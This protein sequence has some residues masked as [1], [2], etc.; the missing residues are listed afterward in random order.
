LPHI[1]AI[2]SQLATSA[3]VSSHVMLSTSTHVRPSAIL[4]FNCLLIT[5]FF[6]TKLQMRS[7]DLV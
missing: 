4:L 2:Y 5:Q 1:Y 3:D 7:T 6:F